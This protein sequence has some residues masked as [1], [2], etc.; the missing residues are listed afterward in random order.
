ML[1]NWVQPGWHHVTESDFA[2]EQAAREREGG[3]DENTEAGKGRQVV[4]WKVRR[5]QEKERGYGG[6]QGRERIKGN[7][8]KENKITPQVLVGPPLVALYP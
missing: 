4:S 7:R 1:C 3:K 5:K 2:Q 8:E 6:F